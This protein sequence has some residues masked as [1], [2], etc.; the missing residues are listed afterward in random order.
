M[1]GGSSSAPIIMKMSD[2]KK[3]EDMPIMVMPPEH[4]HVGGR[5][6]R[7]RHRRVLEDDERKAISLGLDVPS[8]ESSILVHWTR[9]DEGS[10]QE[11]EGLESIIHSKI[12]TV[13]AQCYVAGHTSDNVFDV[14]SD[15]ETSTCSSEVTYDG[16]NV[17][18]RIPFKIRYSSGQKLSQAMTFFIHE[19]GLYLHRCECFADTNLDDS[20]CS[21]DITLQLPGKYL[22]I[23]VSET[24][25]AGDD[26]MHEIR[27]SFLAMQ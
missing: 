21:V 5:R 12:G 11:W 19:S 25:K 24:R 1:K 6:R 10:S 3:M 16:A 20:S 23:T 17:F 9:T 27:T 14:P 8:S 4:E 7:L 22:A 26:E 13:L 2:D 18:A 15:G